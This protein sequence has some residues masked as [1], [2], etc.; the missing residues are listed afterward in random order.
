MS[1]HD[2]TPAVWFRFSPEE[3]IFATRM[4]SASET[5]IFIRLVT[6]MHI[7]GG[8]MVEDVAGLARRC[9]TTRAAMAVAIKTL[10]AYGLIRKIPGG[11]WTDFGEPSVQL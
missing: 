2:K 6:E 9:Q 3:F 5:G 8:P 11:L 7:T 1:D 4:L 10:L